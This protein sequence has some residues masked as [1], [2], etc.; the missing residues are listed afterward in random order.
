MRSLLFV[1]AALL[2]VSVKAQNPQPT[3]T[4]TNTATLQGPDLYYLYWKYTAQNIT[5]E[6][7]VKNA[8]WLLFGVQ[9]S[10]YSDVIVAAMFADG[11][12]H[13]SERT[14]NT[15][16]NALT[17][18]PTL[19]W[20]LLDAFTAN[21]YTVIKFWRDLKV[22]CGQTPSINSLDIGL[23][24]TT[25]VFATGTVF[26]TADSSITVSNPGTTQVNLLPNLAANTQLSCVT[27]PS[28]PQ[29]TS[30]PTAVYANYMDLVEG[31]YRF[32]WNVTDTDLVAELHCQT[33][34]WMAFGFTPNGGMLGSNVVV[35]F[36][37]ADGKAN[38]TDR[39]ITG[40]SPSQILVT[41]NQSV[42]LLASGKVNNYTYFKFTRKINVCDSQHISISVC[43]AFSSQSGSCTF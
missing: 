17:T 15:A 35:G 4:F 23:G 6:V 36:F 42:T 30:T 7:H 9:G 28:S 43:L 37:R 32:Y 22:Q 27:P 1:V 34:G 33:T 12:G 19:K 24:T 18:N 11:T 13:Y 20:Y 39:L 26:N 8:A 40:I 3:E 29:F 2:A 41:A 14:L 21:G 5:F 38:F 31:V 25:L 10:S 16:T